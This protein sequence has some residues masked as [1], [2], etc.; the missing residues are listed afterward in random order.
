MLVNVGKIDFTDLVIAIPAFF[1]IVM[2]PLG[3]SI[4]TGI[5]FGFITY[6]ITSLV[7]GK[8][9]NVSIIVYI[10]SILFILQYILNAIY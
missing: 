5:Q 6:A 7:S 8:G 9:K 4:S 2:M 3:Y 10:F 1:V